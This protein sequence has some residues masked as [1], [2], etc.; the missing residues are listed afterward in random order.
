MSDT[1]AIGGKFFLG[2]GY[3]TFNLAS[4]IVVSNA[5]DGRLDLATF[6]R[7]EWEH[8]FHPVTGTDPVTFIDAKSSESGGFGRAPGHSGSAGSIA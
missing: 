5:G 3:G 7:Y 2:D 4:S 6:Q 1:D 8:G